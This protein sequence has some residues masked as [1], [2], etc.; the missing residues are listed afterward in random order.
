MEKDYQNAFKLMFAYGYECCMFKHII[1]GDQPEVPN[2]MLDSFDPLP[3]EFL[4]NPR[5]PPAPAATDATA[6]EVD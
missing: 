1:C 5:C 6:A 3:L 2:G 4:V